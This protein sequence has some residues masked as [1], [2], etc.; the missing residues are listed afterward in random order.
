MEGPLLNWVRG[1]A[2]YDQLTSL[3]KGLRRRVP[4]FRSLAVVSTD[5][6]VI[7][8]DLPPDVDEDLFAATHAALLSVGER[9]SM[10]S[11]TGPLHEIIVTGEKGKVVLMGAGPNA[12]I[13]AV[14]PEN[15]KLGLLLV[16]LRRAAREVEK[17]L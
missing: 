10:E 7:A 4:E 16:E 8:A 6:L 9:V 15:V 1:L 12:I 2:I 5:G 3:I 17:M 11:G 14:V 13:I